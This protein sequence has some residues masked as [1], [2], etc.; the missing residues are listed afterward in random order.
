MEYTILSDYGVQDLIKQVKSLIDQGWE[1]LGG[2]SISVAGD[3][4]LGKFFQAMIKR[5]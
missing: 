4:Y 2:I 1:P 5:L 3:G